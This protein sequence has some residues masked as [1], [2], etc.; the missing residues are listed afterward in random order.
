M[1]DG[2]IRGPFGAF[3]GEWVDLCSVR[4]QWVGQDELLQVTTG[5]L[6]F[7]GNNQPLAHLSQEGDEEMEERGEATKGGA[8]RSLVAPRDGWQSVTPPN[9]VGNDISPSQ[10]VLSE[11]EWEQTSHPAFYKKPRSHF[12]LGWRWLPPCP[13]AHIN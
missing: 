1:G 10:A 9:V 6:D 12:S 13:S 4:V 5:C 3:E 11:V 8:G 2:C 7:V